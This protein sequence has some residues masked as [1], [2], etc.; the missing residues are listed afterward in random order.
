MTSPPEEITIV[1]P[2]CDHPYRTWW[3][4][5]LN[6]SL[7]SFSEEYITQVTSGRCP[8]CGLVVDLDAL[9]VDEDGSFRA[10]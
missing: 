10:P 9:I 7:D 4:P 1:C 6:L 5:S 8:E 2:G 3:R